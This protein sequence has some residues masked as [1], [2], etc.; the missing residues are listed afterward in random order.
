R[1]VRGTS[2]LAGF[3]ARAAALADGDIGGWLA[4]GEW[5]RDHDLLTQSRA[6][7]EHVLARDPMNAAAHRA[8]GHVLVA[9][10]W[11][12]LEDSYRA[13][14]LVQF[15]GSWVTP[16]ERQALFSERAADEAPRRDRLEA[17]AR[18]R[19]A[20]ARARAAEAEARRVEAEQQ[21]AEGGIPFP[22]LLGGGFGPVFPAEIVPVEP[23]PP[24]V[25][26]VQ[27]PAQGRQE[28][29]HKPVRTKAS[30]SS[31]AVRKDAN[32]TRRPPRGR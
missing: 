13:R 29:P 31:R 17:E 15:E 6:A 21:A 2:A 7:F 24:A 27:V 9:G 10:R 3:R 19:E 20:E 8:L 23:P 11:M 12:T 22:Y 4:L 16:E 28:R 18:I 14:G 32:D 1:L 25:V 26:V 30:S 5:A